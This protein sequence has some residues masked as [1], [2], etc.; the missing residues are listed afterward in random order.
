V[1]A[2]FP[3]PE[4]EVVV[5]WLHVQTVTTVTTDHTIGS[6]TEKSY[7]TAKTQGISSSVANTEMWNEWEEVSH[8]TFDVLTSRSSGFAP[9]MRSN[10]FALPPL[11]I[12]ALKI[13]G[14]VALSIAA[15]CVDDEIKGQKS[16]CRVVAEKVGSGIQQIL[17]TQ[18]E[19]QRQCVSSA[20]AE[21]SPWRRAL[22][23]QVCYPYTPYLQAQSS[24]AQSCEAVPVPQTSVQSCTGPT[25]GLRPVDSAGYIPLTSAGVAT[26]DRVDGRGNLVVSSDGSTVAATAL[27]Q[28]AYPNAYPTSSDTM[29][30]GRSHGGALTTTHTQYEEQTV[31]NGEVFSSEESWGNATAV[32][33]AHAADLWFTYKIRNTGTEYAREI[34]DLAFNIYIGDSSTGSGQAANPAVT[35]FVAP[36]LGGDGKFHNFMPDEEHTY[37]ARR[38]PLTLSQMQ[39]IDVD[40]ACVIKKQ[41]GQIPPAEK[42]PGGKV[43]IVVED[44]TY[45]ID[46]LFYEDAVNAGVLLAIEDGTADG[47][48]AI[49][50]YLIPT[51]GDETV[52]DV[53]ARYF[54]PHGRRR[55]QPDRHLDAGVPQR[56]APLVRRTAGRG[57]GRPADALVQT[58]P[59]HR[60]LVERVHERHGRWVGGLPGHAGRPWLRGPLPLQPGF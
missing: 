60:R 50:A 41:T 30:S 40:P 4:V 42:C 11:V 1:V 31:T 5:A 13:G 12:G 20:M 15:S 43:R 44:F 35:Y 49:D 29:T 7:S 21:E 45:G 27:H 39:A 34:A 55:R 3:V 36:E 23:L 14:T 10:P 22:Q 47:D 8:T 58:R 6:G 16:S 38:I 59:L 37:T 19:V 24:A 28:V 54:P 32:D 18:A 2:G 46:E 57:H 9:M 56:H 48:E 26:Q 25:A 33:S 17:K 53:L 52:L 51:W